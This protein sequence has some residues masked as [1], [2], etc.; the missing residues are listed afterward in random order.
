MIS[1]RE[2]RPVGWREF[3][4]KDVAWFRKES[5]IFDTFLRDLLHLE[6]DSKFR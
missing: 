3:D 1:L 5:C 4:V 2:E 6:V